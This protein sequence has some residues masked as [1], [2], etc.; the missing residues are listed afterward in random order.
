MTCT[1]SNL[2][3]IKKHHEVKVID[4]KL[5]VKLRDNSPLYASS[6]DLISVD[7]TRNNKKVL[8]AERFRYFIKYG[9]Y[10]QNNKYRILTIYF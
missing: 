5:L 4:S 6:K 7:K 3:F 2:Y 10:T 9:K 8:L 1:F